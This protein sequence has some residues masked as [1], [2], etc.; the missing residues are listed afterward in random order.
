MLAICLTLIDND[1][2]KQAFEILYNQ[3]IKLMLHTAY[4][5]LGNQTAAEDAVSE[6]FFRIA[7]NFK[8]VHKEICPK[9][10]NLFVKIVR[11]ISI[12]MYNKNKRQETL[13][14]SEE[15]SDEE[16][17]KFDTSEIRYCLDMLNT[18]DK[19][20]LY[21]YHIYG[22]S[23]RN[24]SKLLGITENAVYKRIQ[25]AMI[26]LKQLLEDKDK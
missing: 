12:D 16:I 21:M 6:A 22:Y 5:I 18:Q 8:I 4:Q 2:D 7:K 9:T 11:N 20:I 14:L 24:I 3:Y 13:P 10:A 26:R 19:D 17:N 1:E 15:I 25:R 23:V